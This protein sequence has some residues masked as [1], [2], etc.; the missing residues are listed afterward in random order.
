MVYEFAEKPKT[1]SVSEQNIMI[2]EKDKLIAELSKTST[3]TAADNS[4]LNKQIDAIVK[5]KDSYYTTDSGVKKMK[6]QKE[7]QL[8]ALN[9]QIA[10][11]NKIASLNAETIKQTAE[12]N[13]Q[14]IAQLQAEKEALIKAFANE[15]KSN[16][17]SYNNE[18]LIQKIIGWVGVVIFSLVVLFANSILS[19]LYLFNPTKA[20]IEAGEQ[21]LFEQNFYV[22]A[23]E[24]QA[25]RGKYV[26]SEVIRL[27]KDALPN[28]RNIDRRVASLAI[29]KGLKS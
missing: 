1:T 25:S 20:P 4:E 9:K 23:N 11:N 18:I 3:A 10:E 27:M 17:E 6:L 13:K 29:Q 26:E 14:K 12:S 16:E 28:Q 7:K 24:V 8:E 2:A 15:N 5:A 22:I 21:D 19:F